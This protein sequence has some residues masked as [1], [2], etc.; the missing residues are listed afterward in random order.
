MADDLTI[1]VSS[2][3]QN[4]KYIDWSPFLGSSNCGYWLTYMYFIVL[5]GESVSTNKIGHS[6]GV[7]LSTYPPLLFRE[8]TSRATVSIS[9]C[10]SIVSVSTIYIS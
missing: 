6:D 1:F 9:M 8:E 2:L 7:A 5:G 4:Y 3:I 10:I